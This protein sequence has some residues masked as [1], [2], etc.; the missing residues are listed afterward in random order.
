MYYQVTNQ[1]INHQSTKEQIDVIAFVTGDQGAIGY[2]RISNRE[3]TRKG[4]LTGD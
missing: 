4:Q 2:V 1:V 3:S